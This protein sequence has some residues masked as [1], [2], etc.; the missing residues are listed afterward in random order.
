MIATG[1]GTIADVNNLDHEYEVLQDGVLD[2][3]SPLN[4]V[5]GRQFAL[6][7]SSCLRKARALL[8]L[9]YSV[10]VEV[11]RSPMRFLDLVQSQIVDKVM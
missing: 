3:H 4:H 6:H 9:I 2:V 1:A 8:A 5:A 7:W 10:E 11:V